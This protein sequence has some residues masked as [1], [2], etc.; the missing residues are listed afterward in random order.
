MKTIRVTLS[1]LLIASEALKSLLNEELAA[2][3]TFRVIDL[4][5]EIGS[6]LSIYQENLKKLHEKYGKIEGTKSVIQKKHMKVYEIEHRK[7]L[8]LVVDIN[9]IRLSRDDFFKYN[10]SGKQ[11]SINIQP[12]VWLGL[13]KFIAGEMP[14]DNLDTDKPTKSKSKKTKSKKQ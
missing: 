11:I 10:S 8:D 12:K 2:E 1:D 6:K 5:E 9:S 13:R 7:L 4:M 14:D 3:T